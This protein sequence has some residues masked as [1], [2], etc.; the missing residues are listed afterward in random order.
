MR[1]H[2][3]GSLVLRVWVD[4]SGQVADAQVAAS[5]GDPALDAHALTS[6]RRWRF[7]VPA[8]KPDG[9]TGELPVRFDEPGEGLARGT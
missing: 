5:S 4:G 2:L 8:D 7:A 1:G 3:S 9:I 6:V